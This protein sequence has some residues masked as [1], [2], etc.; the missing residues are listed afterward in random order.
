M[1]DHFKD[2][3][4]Y[5]GGH[6]PMVEGFKVFHRENP[7]VYDELRKLAL[8]LRDK[9]IRRWGMKGLFEVLR[10]QRAIETSGDEFK[11]N[12][13]YTAFYSRLLMEN[14]QQLIDFFETRISRI[15]IGR[16]VQ[17]GPER[18]Y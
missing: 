6:D 14:E 8:K 7:S 2:V 17:D 3:Q 13:N 11:L 4:M 16:Q 1:A 18:E 5:L 12:N 15:D 9:G 10:W